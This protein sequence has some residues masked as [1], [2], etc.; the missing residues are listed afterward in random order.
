MRKKEDTMKIPVVVVVVA[1][2]EKIFA[3]QFL[4]S[5]WKE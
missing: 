5:F 3:G 4:R 1:F 2:L